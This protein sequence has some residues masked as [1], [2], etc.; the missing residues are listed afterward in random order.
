MKPATA[1]YIPHTPTQQHV[2]PHEKPYQYKPR[3]ETNYRSPVYNY[4]PDTRKNP[5]SPVAH[6]PNVVYDHRTTGHHHGPTAY[7]NSY[8]QRTSPTFHQYYPP[9]AT[10]SASRAP[11]PSGHLLNGIDKYAASNP[12]LPPYPYHAPVASESINRLPP[13]PYAQPPQHHAYHPPA[14]SSPVPISSAHHQTATTRAAPLANILSKPAGSSK[15][16]MY[17]NAP[18]YPNPTALIASSQNEYLIYVTKYPYLRN[19][20]L[21]RAKTY[22]SPYSPDGNFNRDWPPKPTILPAN[23]DPSRAPSAIDKSSQGLGLGYQKGSSLS[24][25]PLRPTPQFQSADAFQRDMAKAPAAYSAMPKWESMMR[26]L[27]S[28]TGSPSPSHAPI[29]PTPPPHA[30]ALP[31]PHQSS[32]PH[33]RPETHTPSVPPP[34]QPLNPVPSALVKSNESPKRPE[35]SPISDVEHGTA[36]RPSVSPLPPPAHS[37]ETVKRS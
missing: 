15:S 31:P 23:A 20:F 30:S 25:P 26:Q 13:F 5:N 6:Q 21:R 28:S 12:P 3:V 34:A 24:L 8:Q 29:P 1:S 16:P 19:A 22:I 27:K 37:G 14:Q 10:P 18:P 11:P 4:S 7:S 36:S 9:Q 32:A 17:A 2:A 33:I 35:Y